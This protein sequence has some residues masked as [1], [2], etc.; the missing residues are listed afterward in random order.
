V[1]QHA[2]L[3]WPSPLHVERAPL[4]D[5]VP[6]H[7]QPDRPVDRPAIPGDLDI[8]VLGLDLVAEEARRLA[9]GVRDQRL[10]LR[11][12]Q[13]EFLVQERR[14][15]RLDVLGLAPGACEP[16][17]PVVGLCRGPDY[18][19][20]AGGSPGQRAFDGAGVGIILRV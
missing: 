11:Q 15:L 2:A 16:Q 5:D 6:G 14:D 8:G 1:Q 12:L 10:G 19:E 17:Q 7:E 20:V 13:P 3:R 9:G 18:A 4:P